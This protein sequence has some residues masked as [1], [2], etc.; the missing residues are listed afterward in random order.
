MALLTVFWRDAGRGVL[1][2]ALAVVL[3]GVA[4][5]EKPLA[6][7]WRGVCSVRGVAF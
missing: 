1:E 4:F 7:F 3:E 2:E 5:L 6:L